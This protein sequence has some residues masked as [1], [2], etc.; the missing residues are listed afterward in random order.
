MH[1]ELWTEHQRGKFAI[2]FA[3]MIAEEGIFTSIYNPRKT[4]MMAGVMKLNNWKVTG[5]LQ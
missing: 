1:A 4:F 2:T 5:F 3:E